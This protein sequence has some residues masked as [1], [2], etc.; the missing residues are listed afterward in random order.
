MSDDGALRRL[1]S[2]DPAVSFL[3]HGSFGACPISIRERHEALRLRIERDPA[4]FFTRELEGLLDGARAAVAAFLGAAAEDLSFVPNATAGVNTVLR[5]LAF[6]PGDEL[7]TT[8]HAYNACR[9]ALD[10]AAEQAGA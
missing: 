2:L 8:D 5:S 6:A 1:W 9:N 3:N 4:R 7:L 10:H